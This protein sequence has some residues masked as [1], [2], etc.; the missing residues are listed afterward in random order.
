MASGE[1]DHTHI[2]AWFQNGSASLKT[3]LPQNHPFMRCSPET[4]A[5]QDS[6]PQPQPLRRAPWLHGRVWIVLMCCCC[7]TSCKTQ[8]HTHVLLLPALEWPYSS[9]IASI[10]T[11]CARNRAMIRLRICLCLRRCKGPGGTPYLRDCLV[12]AKPC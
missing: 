9:P 10:G 2:Y 1:Q 5:S 4:Q 8:K 12:K 6:I 3:A 7:L 11:P